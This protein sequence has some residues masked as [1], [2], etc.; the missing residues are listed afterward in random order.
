MPLNNLL[1]L[2][3]DDSV[4]IDID[5]E[6]TSLMVLDYIQLNLEAADTTGDACTIKILDE[7]GDTVFT[8]TPV[9]FSLTTDT[10]FTIVPEKAVY[11]P[12]GGAIAIDWDN[13]DDLELTPIV[14]WHRAGTAAP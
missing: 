13:D 10:E 2:D 1:K 9:N 12:S 11:V 3:P 8:F 7:D 4:P 14:T 5:I 6:A